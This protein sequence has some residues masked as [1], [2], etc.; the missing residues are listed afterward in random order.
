MNDVKEVFLANKWNSSISQ[1]RNKVTSISR[2]FSNTKVKCTWSN[3]W[4]HHNVRSIVAYGTSNHRLAIETRW[5]MT[6]PSFEDT[7]L[8]HFCSCNVVAI[9]T[10][11]VLEC[12]IY[13]PIR[14]RF[15]SLFETIV[16]GSLKSFLKSG[17]S[18][19]H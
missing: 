10:H 16:G 12:P 3:H 11:L 2:I 4:H 15:P 8:C 14:D 13:N 17:P 6:I 7:R 19:W 18:S 9:E 1:G 5:W